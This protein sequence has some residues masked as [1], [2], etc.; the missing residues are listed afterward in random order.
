M[1]RKFPNV[2]RV[3]IDLETLAVKTAPK[4]IS[5]TEQDRLL[6]RDAPDIVYLRPS[7]ISPDFKGCNRFVKKG[8]YARVPF[9]DE[10]GKYLDMEDVIPKEGKPT[11]FV[12][13]ERREW[14][15]KKSLDR[16]L[17]RDEND[18]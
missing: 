2:I 14:E 16:L 11:K 3:G 10:D 18:K 8:E 13:Y 15:I 5:A 12:I 9:S 6:F 1:P 4:Y 7:I 17:P